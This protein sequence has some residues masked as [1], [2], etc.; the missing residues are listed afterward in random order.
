MIKLSR[1]VRIWWIYC[2]TFTNPNPL[3]TN[4]MNI[5]VPCLRSRRAAWAVRRRPACRGTTWCRGR[6]GRRARGTPGT[7]P[8][9][10]RDRPRC[11]P[12]R[13]TSRGT[14]R[15]GHPVVSMWNSRSVIT[16]KFQVLRILYPLYQSR[17]LMVYVGWQ[18][19]K[20]AIFFSLGRSQSFYRSFC[21]LRKPPL[22]PKLRLFTFLRYSIQQKLIHN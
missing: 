1:G 20:E 22:Q 4:L 6:G 3:S 16:G 7:C 2:I 21:R 15:W 19:S 18:W 10:W 8:P 9:R 13:G 11:A 14:P 17:Q 5:S 12:P